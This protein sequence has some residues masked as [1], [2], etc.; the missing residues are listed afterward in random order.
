MTPKSPTLPL[1][2]D[3]PPAERYLARHVVV[4]GR[5]CGLAVAG[6]GADGTLLIEPFTRETPNTVYLPGTLHITL[7]PLTFHHEV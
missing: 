3:L 4:D 6:I 7:S 2:N 5:D 1:S